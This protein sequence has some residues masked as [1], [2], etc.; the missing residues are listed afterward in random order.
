M[1]FHCDKCHA[2]AKPTPSDMCIYWHSGS[3][4]SQAKRPCV[5]NP[6]PNTP[7][8]LFHPFKHQTISQNC[9]TD[10]II[11]LVMELIRSKYPL[12]HLSANSSS[13]LCRVCLERGGSRVRIP[14]APEFFG[15]SH[16]SDFK[17]GTPAAT[18]LGVWR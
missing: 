15:S 5:Q 3:S 11:V 13:V 1:I 7:Q 9:L 4:R 10:L 18:L 6:S 16:I 12:Y 17:F 14:L 2:Q 8:T